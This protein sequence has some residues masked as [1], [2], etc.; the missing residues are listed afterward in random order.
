MPEVAILV[1]VIVVA[2]A[3]D[4]TNGFHDTANAMAPSVA[5]GALKPKP[6]VALSAILNLVGA[7]LSIEVART[8]GSGI[9]D[10][11]GVDGEQLMLIVLSGLTGAIVWNVLTWLF[12]L[13]SSS[14][15]A[16]FGG[17]IGATIAALGISGVLWGGVAQKILIPALFA[18]VI[19]AV[20]AFGGTWLVHRVTRTI[21]E[22]AQQRS[23]RWGQIGAASLMSLAHGTNDA[24]KTMGVI[25][26]ALV[27]H[28]SL[29]S[30]SDM[31]LWVRF[32]CAIAIALGT[33]MGGWRVIRTLGKGIV[34]I[35]PRQGMAA[36]FSSASIIL[37]SSQLGLPLS[38]THVAS[39]SVIGSGL[40]REDVKVRWSVA[41]R[42]L[43]AWLITL[44]AAGA[45]GAVCLLIAN[46]FGHF[47][48][49]LVVTTILIVA[50]TAMW[51]RS[52]LSPVGHHNVTDEWEQPKA[53]RKR[54]IDREYSAVASHI[55]PLSRPRKR[56]RKASRTNRGL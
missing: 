39:G 19:A 17:L 20:V 44:P 36:D 12:G 4:F 21:S 5:T 41:R 53:E 37:T 30:S 28:G 3:F 8:V 7:F 34:D 50:C 23:F 15:H 16:L 38:T 33:Y 43:I 13:P 6:A 9:V 48:G 54:G 35:S 32:A 51:L 42:M 55:A 18:P 49:A 27:A 24:Q 25:F 26:L 46:L 52:R 1:I 10:L 56:K 11:T 31:P 29:D 22:R 45:V 2:L 40:A 47:W 14:S